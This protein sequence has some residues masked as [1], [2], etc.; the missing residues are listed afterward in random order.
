MVQVPQQVPDKLED[1]TV[2]TLYLEVL[3]LTVEV[4]ALRVMTVRVLQ[5]VTEQ[6]AAE[7]VAAA[8]AT[9]KLLVVDTVAATEVVQYIQ[10]KVTTELG[11]AL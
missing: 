4:V 6:V 5:Q 9:M 8:A 2:A 11:Q 1:L 7:Q 10:I 3:L